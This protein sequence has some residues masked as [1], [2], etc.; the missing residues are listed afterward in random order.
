MHHPPHSQ[1]IEKER[2]NTPRGIFRS[3]RSP[4]KDFQRGNDKDRITKKEI[5]TR[6][7][8]DFRKAFDNGGS[9]FKKLPKSQ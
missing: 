9:S 6:L 2:R 1:N 7:I 5:C 3:A 4:P 8:V